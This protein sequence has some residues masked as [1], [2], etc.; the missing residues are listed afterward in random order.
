MSATAASPRQFPPLALAVASALLWSLLLGLSLQWN[1]LN[2]TRQIMDM[3]YDKAKTVRDKDMVFRLWAMR[4][5]GVFVPISD[6]VRPADSLAHL[7][8]RDIET[9]DGRKLTLLAPAIVLREMMDEYKELYGVRGR[10]T[11]MR[12]LNPANAPDPWE[13]R[14]LEAFEQREMD[15]IWEIA[16]LDGEPHLR[17]LKSWDMEARCVKCH[18]ILGYKVGDLRGATGTNLPLTDY[19]RRIDETRTKLTTSHAT[20]WLVG[21]IGIA[22]AGWIGR[23]RTR[24]RQQYVESLRIYASMFEQSNEAI[25]RTDAQ[26]RIVEVNPSFQRLTGYGI[27]DLRG[28][29]PSI[30]SAGQTDAET[31]REMWRDIEE[32]GGWS[33]ELWDRRKD[34]RIYPKWLTISTLRDA[35]GAIA[36]YIGLFT[37]ITER[38]EAQER[39]HRIA[40]YDAV[41]GLPNRH[42]FQERLTM[43]VEQARL[44]D[45]SLSLVFVDI[46]NFK[47]I[48]D[49]H[50]HQMGD[51]LLRSIAQR[52]TNALRAGDIVARLGGDEFAVIIEG[53][54]DSQLMPAIADKLV[55]ELS[56]PERIE[57]REI[58]TGASLGVALF[59]EDAD[60]EENLLRFA[61]LAMY[62]AKES[63]KNAWRRFHSQ[64]AGRSAKRLTME[65]ELRHALDDDCIEAHYQPQIDLRTRR[66]GGVEALARWRHPVRGYISPG[67]F[68]PVA[69]DSG[70]I[71]EIGE[72]ILRDACRQ[73]LAWRDAGIGPLR[74]AVN[75]SARQ[76]QQ[77][78]FARSVL[79]TL[80]TS[81][82]PTALIE[83]EITESM[84]M[85]HAQRARSMLAELRENGLAVAIDDFGTG[86]SS[87]AQLKNLPV[88]KLKIDKSFIDDIAHN[89]ADLAIVHAIAA[90][91][92][93]LELDLIAEGVEN[94][95]QS[96]LLQQVGCHKMQGYAYSRP[97]PAQQFIDFCRNFRLP[98]SKT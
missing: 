44:M 54:A 58:T 57:G 82:C 86:Y 35:S 66:V 78:H 75:V 73:A 28:Q 60:N 61:D 7:P 92:R 9:T 2:V 41:T 15:E 59:P 79:D 27:D 17:Y 8:D 72:K 11:G 37:D 21:L 46:D 55:R 3:A 33:G 62:A 80:A 98:D 90:L 36:H 47:L 70:L 13:K 22:W 19:Y 4:H 25:M 69:E 77:A 91:A 96:Q 32:K 23:R 85:Q 30:L 67:E 71:R 16:D 51:A 12:Y 18:A 93:S 20:V 95:V 89:R 87:M 74:V 68:I 81:G 83:I 40:H 97:L 63:G 84:L 42:F 94:D 53:L 52:L 24:E 14:Q 48:N 1:T 39:L 5:G 49:T 88:G 38:K 45:Q 6:S 56:R 65:Q 64:M 34:G 29:N 50:G 76:L 31:Y 10:I 26:N 43:A